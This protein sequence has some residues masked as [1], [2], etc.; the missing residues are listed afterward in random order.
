MKYFPR[1]FTQFCFACLCTLS[2][3]SLSHAAPPGGKTGKKT[4]N[5]EKKVR[6]TMK[7]LMIGEETRI[8]PYGSV[9]GEYHPYIGLKLEH[10]A[11]GL[12]QDRMFHHFKIENR[13]DYS[14][15]F[16][17]L[18]NSISSETVKYS[19]L[20]KIKSDRDTYYYGVGLGTDKAA[21]TFA[22]YESVFW[23][24][25]IEK[26]VSENAVLRMSSGFWSFQSGLVDG[27]EFE[28]AAD[29]RYF[30]SRF[31]LSDSKLINYWKPAIDNYWSAYVETGLPINTTVASY[32]RFNVESMTRFPV[33]KKTRLGIATRLEF[34]LTPNREMLPYF[35]LPEIGSE[36]GLR[37]YSRERFRDFAILAVSLEYSFPITKRIDGFLLTD[38]A[39]TAARPSKLFHEDFYQSFGMGLRLKKGDNPI[40]VGIATCSEG[41]KLFS[42]VALGKAW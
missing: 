34:L 31:A 14:W 30:S 38:L 5:N 29:A 13:R 11:F 27:L 33:Y 17:Y 19:F 35:A 10:A 15:K 24:G 41:L 37:G 32:V 40:S 21:R 9:D 39:Q 4:K 6:L 1:L 26:A 22:S 28:R 20:F 7:G 25:E 2:V 36:S 16:R 18:A 3:A 8:L 23:G 42:S 12:Q